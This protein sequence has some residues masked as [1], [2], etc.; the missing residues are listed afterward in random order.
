MLSSCYQV[1]KTI[2]AYRAEIK[3]VLTQIKYNILSWFP[4][5]IR[6][7]PQYS[8][9]EYLL[10][11]GKNQVSLHA[12]QVEYLNL[13]FPIKLVVSKYNNGLKEANLEKEKIEVSFSK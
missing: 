10:D 13:H 9:W 8:R 12:F 2:L 3:L 4:Y 6:L 1:V 5:Q 11:I 7:F